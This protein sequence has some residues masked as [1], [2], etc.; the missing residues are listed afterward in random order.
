ME[1]LNTS[2][3]FMLDASEL[4]QDP[5]TIATSYDNSKKILPVNSIVDVSIVDAHFADIHPGN[6]AVEGSE[7]IAVVMQMTAP[8]IVSG[9]K[10]TKKF[11]LR[12]TD[13]EKRK[14]AKDEFLVLDKILG[15]HMLAAMKQ[16]QSVTDALLKQHI[17]FGVTRISV[18]VY[19]VGGSMGNHVQ[20]IGIT[21]DP[22][23]KGELIDPPMPMAQ[24]AAQPAGVD[25]VNEGDWMNQPSAFDNNAPV[26]FGNPEGQY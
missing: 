21:K 25:G 18:G 6:Q 12:H 13:G 16:G 23:I 3:T 22:I 1:N 24:A 20:G 2:K 14:K 11:K 26:D 5:S 15:G 19:N 17:M 8:E 4:A 7:C 9:F 10:I